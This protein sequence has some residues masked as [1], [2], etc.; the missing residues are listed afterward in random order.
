MGGRNPC[1]ELTVELW[2]AALETLLLRLCCLLYP[3]CR[4]LYM[5]FR[6]CGPRFGSWLLFTRHPRMTLPRFPAVESDA[7]DIAL[8]VGKDIIPHFLSWAYHRILASCGWCQR[9]TLP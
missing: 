1:L 3:F 8:R 2:L 5:R 7:V 9:A 6:L 4:L